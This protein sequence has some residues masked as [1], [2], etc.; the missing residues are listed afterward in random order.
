MKLE[1]LL[2]GVPFAAQSAANSWLS[3]W[4]PTMHTNKRPG[5]ALRLS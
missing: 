4:V 5:A 3:R 2:E 1:Q